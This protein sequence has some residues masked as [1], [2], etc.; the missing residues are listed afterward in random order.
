M[1]CQPLP[2]LAWFDEARA[3]HA[4]HQDGH[5]L[6][7]A[8]AGA[9]HF[10]AS[11]IQG[12]GVVRHHHQ[13]GLWTLKQ[14]IGCPWRP[15]HWREPSCRP[16]G[17][18]H[19]TKASPANPAKGRTCHQEQ[20]QHSR[21]Q[22]WSQVGWMTCQG[23]CPLPSHTQHPGAQQLLQAWVHLLQSQ[24]CVPLQYGPLERVLEAP[25][26]HRAQDQQV[27]LYA[28]GVVP[29]QPLDPRYGVPLRP[30]L[31]NLQVR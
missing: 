16:P 15:A 5:V 27:V 28:F 7:E 21:S 11:A 18:S 12:H 4:W 22:A 13:A 29:G 20:V 1:A 14:Q 8:V 25:H 19:P 23:P 2:Q 17:K 31:P 3:V 9:P 6:L 26:H 30:V 24:P 10:A